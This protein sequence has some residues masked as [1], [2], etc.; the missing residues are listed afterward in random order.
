MTKS[1]W[2]RIDSTD[3]ENTKN[4][5]SVVKTIKNAEIK[6]INGQ[7]YVRFVGVT[8]KSSQSIRKRHLFNI[9]KKQTNSSTTEGNGRHYCAII[10][11]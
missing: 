8:S 9:L 11:K 4:M 5:L 7:T 10:L 1:R 3:G 2:L 6:T